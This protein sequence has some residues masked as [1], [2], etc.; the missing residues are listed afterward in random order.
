MGVNFY[1][2]IPAR[3]IARWQPRDISVAA[4]TFEWDITNHLGALGRGRDLF[5]IVVYG[6][7]KHGVAVEGVELLEDLGPEDGEEV[8]RDEHKAFNGW[9]NL[10]ATYRLALG[11]HRP[12]VSYKI[13]V[14]LRAKGGT[15]SWGSV[16]L[17]RH[18]LPP[19]IY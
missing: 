15:N 16:W 3:R 18:P 14:K 8:K 7:G 11:Y 9:T 10:Y 5:V 19:D 17:S 6:Q 13:R 12:E 1:R 4:K 2:P